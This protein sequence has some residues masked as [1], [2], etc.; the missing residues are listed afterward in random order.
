LD[1][2]GSLHNGDRQKRFKRDL[3]HGPLR[4]AGDAK[5]VLAANG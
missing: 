4:S 3:G 5:H 1:A 2:P